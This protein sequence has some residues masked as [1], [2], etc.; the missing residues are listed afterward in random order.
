M[1]KASLQIA[2]LALILL[3]VCAVSRVAMRGAYTAAIP[4]GV[5][6][7]R[8]EDL[9]FVDET[10]GVIDRGAPQVRDG[11]IHVPIYPL[12]AGE[13]YV[14]V[15]AGNDREYVMH[16]QVGRFGTIYDGVT[17]GFTG[18]TV[19]LGAFTAFCLAVAAIMLYTYRRATGPAF[20]AYD[21]MYAAG[22][23]L[24]G[25]LTGL[26]MLAITVRHMLRPYE[27][28]MLV[29]YTAITGASWRFMML[30]ALPVVAFAAAMAVSNAALVR[31]EGF[32]PKNMLGI[33]IG[34]ALVAGEALAFFLY[35]RNVSGSEREIRLWDTLCNVYATGFA[36]FEC[37]L[38]GAIV[39]GLKAARHSPD[40]GADCIVILGCKFRRDGTLTPLLKGRVDRAI[41]YWKRQREATGREAVLMPSG[42]QG[43]DEP[44]PEAQA[45]KRYLLEQ[46]IPEARI[47]TEDKSHNTFQNMQF[48]RVLIEQNALGPTVVFSTT[49]YHVFRSGVWA[50]RAG[51]QAEGMGSRTRWWYWPNAFMRE[52]AGLMLNHIPQELMLLAAMLMLFGALSMALG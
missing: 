7:V 24:F 26:T 23:A 51:L 3:A 25:L 13:T 45:M 10:P 19:V 41:D 17:G 33:G 28:N 42:G 34:L 14:D 2:V 40:I 15:S 12:H 37:M 36:W 20:Y 35:S 47:V 18:D 6:N 43:A 4:I 21:T 9:R 29:A 38:I 32:S 39:C 5:Q 8:A 22:L 50:R 46:G 31:H 30:T 44:M 48:S 52:C 1:K 49:N 27:Y 16:L 11:F